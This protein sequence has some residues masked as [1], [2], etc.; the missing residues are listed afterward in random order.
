M[1]APW[2]RALPGG[3][4]VPPRVQL[5]WLPRRAPRSHGPRLA[6]PLA[7]AS[8]TNDPVHELPS[9]HAA[10]VTAM[11]YNEPADTVISTDA[12]GEWVA[13]ETCGGWGAGFTVSGGQHALGC[14]VAARVLRGRTSFRCASALRARAQA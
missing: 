7:P 11:R 8:G 13:P 4:T 1:G 6:P 10:P 9:L 12:K 3:A 2:Q 14:V 5:S